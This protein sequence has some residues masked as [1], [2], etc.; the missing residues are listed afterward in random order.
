MPGQ[1]LDD[2]RVLRD[3]LRIVVVYESVMQ[4]RDVDEIDADQNHDHPPVSEQFVGV[5]RFRMLALFDTFGRHGRRR[6]HV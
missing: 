3:V 6:G 2:L 1:A 5:P 4:Q